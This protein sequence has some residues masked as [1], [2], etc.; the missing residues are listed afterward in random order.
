[1]VW[2]VGVDAVLEVLDAVE[3]FVVVELLLL[4]VEVSRDL[5]GFRGDDVPELHTGEWECVVAEHELGVNINKEAPMVA[6]ESMA[7]VGQVA[8]GFDG[9]LQILVEEA[10]VD[11]SLASD[12]GGEVGAAVAFEESVLEVAFGAEL[13][14]A[15]IG[16]ADFVIEITGDDDFFASGLALFNKGNKVGDV[17]FTDEV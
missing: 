16:E 3:P 14:E 6:V 9:V 12:V 15:G 4:S 10:V 8:A 11:D 2:L 13:G 5:V 17:V 7:V 1:M